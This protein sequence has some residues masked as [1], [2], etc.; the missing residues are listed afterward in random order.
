MFIQVNQTEL[1]TLAAEG[2]H[3]NFL[4]EVCTLTLSLPE[5]R[6]AHEFEEATGVK[7]RPMH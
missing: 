5:H 6:S 1:E 4:S 7:P 2:L 3:C